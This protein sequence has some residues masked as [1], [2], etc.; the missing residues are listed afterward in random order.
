M[1][2]AIKDVLR[3]KIANIGHPVGM[4]MP[5]SEATLNQIAEAVINVLSQGKVK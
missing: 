5:P 3:E 1:R 4:G 2:E